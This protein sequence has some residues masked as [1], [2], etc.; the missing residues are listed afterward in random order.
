MWSIPLTRTVAASFCDGRDFAFR[1]CLGHGSCLAACPDGWIGAIIRLDVATPHI[2]CLQR[3]VRPGDVAL[4]LAFGLYLALGPPTCQ[5]PL[6]R[7]EELA[8]SAFDHDRS[9]RHLPLFAV[10]HVAR[11]RLHANLK[12]NGWRY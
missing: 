8:F 2:L 4:S 12:S 6:Y 1:L 10:S 3:G 7:I 9:L 5:S 11:R